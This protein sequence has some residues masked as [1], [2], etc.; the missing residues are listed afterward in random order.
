[1]PLL[2]GGF[3]LLFVLAAI[4]VTLFFDPNDFRE[5]IAEAV[6]AE[7]G[8]ELVIDGDISLTLFPWLAVEVG[9]ATLGDAPG[10]GDD[11]MLSFERASF[12]VR[13]LPAILKQEIIVGAA[14]LEGLDLNLKID[15]AGRSNWSDLAES[16]AADDADQS[17]GGGGEIDINRI[18][19]V[20]AT[21]TYTNAESDERIVLSGVD[22]S[23]GRL[24]SDGLDVPVSGDLAFDVQPAALGGELEFAMTMAYD[25][26]A[27][28]LTVSG[29]DVDGSVAGVAAV[30][31]LLSV[32]TDEIAVDTAASSIRMA[33]LVVEALEMTI[34]ADVEPFGY[35]DRIT[36]PGAR[37]DRCVLAAQGDG[38]VRRRAAGHGRPGRTR[39][40]DAAGERTI[41]GN[42]NRDA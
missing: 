28:L 6:E 34:R 20:D 11:P 31:T 23:V 8:R 32:R 16:G 35:A 7:T 30:P 4:A 25:A 5:D 19:L 22:L 29:V 37:R 24:R 17:D 12:S 33:A 13:L 1:M 38:L 2:V 3:I 26:D 40:R 21:I 41:E 9:A 27:G 42:R 10:F 14:D 15:A 36:P 18:D 39:P